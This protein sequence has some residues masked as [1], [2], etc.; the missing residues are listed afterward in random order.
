[1]S[2]ALIEEWKVLKDAGVNIQKT[3]NQWRHAY[4]IK[5]HGINCS[6]TTGELIVLLTR[7]KY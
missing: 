1:M 6:S 2:K 4:K 3:L 5:I 7:E